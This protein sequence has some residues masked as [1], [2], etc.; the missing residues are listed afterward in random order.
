MVFYKGSYDRWINMDLFDHRSG[1]WAAA[2]PQRPVEATSP[3][4]SSR[5]S[6]TAQQLKDRSGCGLWGC[7]LES[8]LLVSLMAASAG[9]HPY[10]HGEGPIP[11]SEIVWALL[12]TSRRSIYRAFCRGLETQYSNTGN[13]N[14]TIRVPYAVHSNAMVLYPV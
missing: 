5:T 2:L 1:G 6:S 10:I 11:C 13:T 12:G 3:P 4:T 8:G 14:S 7:C 9:V